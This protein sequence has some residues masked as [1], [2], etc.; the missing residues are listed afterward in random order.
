MEK[1]MNGTTMNKK[2]NKA[3]IR[4]SFWFA[5][6]FI[7]NGYATGITG[8]S[9]G[10]AV[11]IIY[12]LITIVSTFNNKLHIRK[13]ELL[14]V[15]CYILLTLI[16]LLSLNSKYVLSIDIMKG[17]MRLVLWAIMISMVTSKYF[18]YSELFKWLNR[19][20]IVLTIYIIFQTIMFYVASIY[21]PNI[22]NFAILVPYDMGYANYDILSASTILRPGSLLSESSFYGNY[23]LCMLCMCLGKINDGT[24]NHRNLFKLAIFYSMGVVLSTSTGAIVFLPVIWLMFWK[25]VPEKFKALLVFALIIVLTFAL[26][27]SVDF[28]TLSG[29]GGLAGSLSYAINKFQ[30]M[31]TSSRIGRSYQLINEVEGI[32]KL[33]GVGYGNGTNYIRLTT[34]ETKIYMNSIT[35]IIVETGLIGLFVYLI[36]MLRFISDALRKKDKV[37]F[38]L[39][40]VCFVKAFVSGMAFGTYGIMFLFI[41]YGRLYVK[42]SSE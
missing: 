37:S 11:F 38:A 21:I 41:A 18:H 26:V 4:F 35:T 7:L 27:T 19:I 32:N 12:S 31:G 23:V 24:T 17:M 28:E 20:G 3:I 5:L 6:S 22:Y 39:L 1:N 40:L 42:S 8:I 34:G 36:Y 30:Y 29:Q 9:L 2:T 33:I 25:V 13:N 10:S 15:I 14:L 16:S